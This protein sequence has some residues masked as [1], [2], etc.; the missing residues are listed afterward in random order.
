ME[1]LWWW[2]GGQDSISSIAYWYTYLEEGLQRFLQSPLKGCID[3]IYINAT[4][5][6][7]H[8]SQVSCS[9]LYP[10]DVS[11]SSS[12]YLSRSPC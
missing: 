5:V 11:H 1:W 4:V 12:T 7:D 9:N 8:Y 10:Q 6:L 3:W 2:D